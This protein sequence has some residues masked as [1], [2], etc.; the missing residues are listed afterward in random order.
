MRLFFVR[1]RLE[2]IQNI[3]RPQRLG[4]LHWMGWIMNKL[5][6]TG[7]NGFVGKFLCQALRARDIAFVPAVRDAARD[8]QIAVGDLNANT[9]WRDA[10]SGCDA[11][12]HLAARVHM[13][14]DQVAD[15]LAVYRTV[16]CDATLNLARQAALT[17]VKRF[18]YVSSIKV[19]GEQ[20]WG[21]QPFTVFDQPQPHD[22]YAQSKWEAEVALMKW[23]H[24]SGMEV[25]IVR[26]PLVYGPGVGA[27]F[28]R[29][30]RLVRMGVP[31]PLGAVYNRRSMVALDNLVD[32]LIACVHHPAAVGRTFLVSDDR[33]VGTPELI[34]MLAAAMERR[35]FLF[36][37][38]EKLLVAGATMLGKPAAAGRLLG[39]L[40]VDIGYTRQVLSWS[41]RVSMDYAIDAT[42]T[43]FLSRF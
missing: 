25:A 3:V 30:M 11:V 2:P 5:L 41:P 20:T 14:S 26:P 33:D 36:P 23:A 28:L 4:R 31:L 37:I 39:S 38:P 6:V 7:A 19:N 22:P 35:A 43:H 27:N 10:L 15:P 21:N 34:Q 16:N 1:W 24:Q 12:I 29:L 8:G 13:M 40:Q 32:L 42:V 17:G 9:C 18:V